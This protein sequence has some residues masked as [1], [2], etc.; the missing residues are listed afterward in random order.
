MYELMGWEELVIY[1]MWTCHCRMSKAGGTVLILMERMLLIKIFSRIRVDSKM[2]LLNHL[3][4][5][6]DLT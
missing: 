4:V 3:V 1:Y 5:R 6:K 2:L